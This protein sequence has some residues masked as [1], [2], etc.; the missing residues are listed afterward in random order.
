MK[1]DLDIVLAILGLFI[2]L[3][4]AIYSAIVLQREVYIIYGAIL[5]IACLLWLLLGRKISI[6]YNYS[7]HNRTYVQILAIFFFLT[8]TISIILLHLRSELFVR[9]LSV[10]ILIS[11]MAGI[12]ALEIIYSPK[13]QYFLLIIIQTLILGLITQLSLVMLFPDVIG[14]DPALHKNLIDGILFSGHTTPGTDYSTT[15][16]FHIGTVIGMLI[17]SVSYSD[18]TLIIV[19]LPNIILPI[20]SIF[21]LGKYL[22]NERVALMATL[23]LTMAPYHIYFG[24][25]A[26]PNTFASLTTPLILYILLIL[27]RGKISGSPRNIKNYKINLFGI[28]IILMITLIM[29]HPVASLGM[30][31][32]L[33]IIWGINS[34]YWLLNSNEIKYTVSAGT[35]LFFIILMASWWTYIG[36]HLHYL[37]D[38][39][40]APQFPSC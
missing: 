34:A 35:M 37:W 38:Q 12:V 18:A 21:L 13:H 11:T 32:I 16:L 17:G 28:A 25:W 27:Y 9:P 30:A 10:F 26:V 36:N 19:T 3:F 22:F 29:T 14:I 1:I 23:L 24:V 8:L 39:L 40:L 5:G 33:F 6:R 20:L 31:L 2:S 7:F 4:M 15:P